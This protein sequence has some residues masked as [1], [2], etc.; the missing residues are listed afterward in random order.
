MIR[1][2]LRVDLSAVVLYSIST[3]TGSGHALD[4]SESLVSFLRSLDFND[5]V[6]VHS[7]LIVLRSHSM[8]RQRGRLIAHT[9]TG[10]KSNHRRD[11]VPKEEIPYEVLCFV[12]DALCTCNSVIQLG[13][14]GFNYMGYVVHGGS[15]GPAVIHASQQFSSPLSHP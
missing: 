1:S 9:E 6:P 2:P 5:L 10:S 13:T 12:F 4:Q 11:T 15:S 7:D 14:S 3:D 8:M